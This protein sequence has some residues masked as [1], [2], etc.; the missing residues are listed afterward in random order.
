MN[1]LTRWDP[2]RE[3][4]DMQGR[5]S[6]ILGRPSRRE[7]GN[8][9]EALAVPGWSPPADILEDDKEY[10]IRVEI[11]GVEQ[12]A[13]KVR[14]ENR[15]LTITGERKLVAEESQWRMH[16]VE[17]AYGTF[18]RS[19][20]LPEDADPEKVEARFHNGV[21]EVHVAK[22]ETSRPKTIDVKIV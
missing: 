20:M 19:F 3:L 12:N 17:R 5:L 22:S 8:D 18:A 13:V 7:A 9:R 6:S 1:A 11:P 21:L 4:E 10:V 15:A 14:M 16:R 2:F